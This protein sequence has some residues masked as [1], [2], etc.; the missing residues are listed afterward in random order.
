MQESASLKSLS[1]AQKLRSMLNKNKKET[2]RRYGPD[3]TPLAKVQTWAKTSAQ[4]N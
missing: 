3:G 4:M 2:T 1:P